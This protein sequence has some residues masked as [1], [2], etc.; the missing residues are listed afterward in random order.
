M[1]RKNLLKN[2]KGVAEII[3]TVLM[4]LLSITAIFMLSSLFTN[5]YKEINLSPKT[6]CITLKI[7]TPIRINKACYNSVTENI[8]ISLSK[9]A[10]VHI[11]DIKFILSKKEESKI[12][13]C[14]SG[15]DTCSIIENGESRK[16][17]LSVIGFG[18]QDKVAISSSESSS[19]C[20]L[21]EEEIVDC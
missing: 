7:D 14:G 5:F 10:D 2:K 16:Y 19:E 20:I 13:S 1:T 9:L 3:T 6:N 8:E 17:F 18:K 12:W 21:T 11:N 15:C 4:I